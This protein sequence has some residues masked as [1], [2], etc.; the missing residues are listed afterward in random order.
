VTVREA[1]ER[2]AAELAGAGVE[3]PDVDAEFLLG[4]VLGVSRTALVLE[5]ERPLPEA[6]RS[7]FDALVARRTRRE[8]LAYVLGEW[9]F[10]RLTL[11][12]DARALVPR[13]ETEVVAERCLTLLAGH[14]RP[15]VL[16]LGTGSGAIALAIA[17]EHPGATVVAVERS[18]EALALARENVDRTGLGER[19]ALVQGDIEDAPARDFDLVVSN[20]PYVAPDE[21]DALPPEVRDWEPAEALVSD[22]ATDRVVETALRVLA[23][24]GALV[25]ESADG[26]A[27][28]IADRLVESGFDDVRISPDLAGRDRVVEGRRP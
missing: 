26:R 20:P 12:T 6:Q 15:A 7:A 17:D 16:D 2:A 8:P 11:R 9:G 22:D 10:R 27:A 23:P 4:H 24:L 5:R 1:L 19:I 13:P 14:D 3:T 18:P 28:R 21:F 25:L